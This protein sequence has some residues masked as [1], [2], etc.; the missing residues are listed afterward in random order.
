MKNYV[1]AA[2]YAYPF[3]K[4]ID[5]EY[6]EHIFNRAALSYRDQRSTERIA[7][8]IAG[9]IV[10]KRRLVWLREKITLVLE[11]LSDA[12]RTLVSIRYF[13]KERAVKRELRTDGRAGAAWSERKYFRMQSR[14]GEKVGAM[15][16]AAGVSEEAFVSELLP[17]ELIARL[18]RF[19]CEGKDRKVTARERQWVRI[20]HSSS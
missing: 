7:T 11:R 12:E 5:K 9:E 20:G 4:N 2:L 15:L 18:Y 16:E 1:K 17:I 6:D 14:L 3:L 13:G 8:Y 19:V 10:E